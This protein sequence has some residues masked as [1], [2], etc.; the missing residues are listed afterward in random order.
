M[1]PVGQLR[2]ARRVRLRRGVARQRVARCEKHGDRERGPEQVAP[3][4]QPGEEDE[5]DDEHE[6]ERHRHPRRSERRANDRPQVAVEE[7]AERQLE[8]RLG[9]Q[10]E[11]DERDLDDADRPRQRD[12][13]EAPLEPLRHGPTEHEQPEAEPADHE[14]ERREREPAHRVLGAARPGGSVRRGRFRRLHAHAEREDAGDDVTVAAERLP[15]YG[16]AA[17]R[18]G[19]Q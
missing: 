13:V 6:R 11:R 14:R 10:D 9:S 18:Q 3:L 19:S 15:A 17:A 5:R 2:P 8:H 1:D 7:R 4:R 12:E 16:V